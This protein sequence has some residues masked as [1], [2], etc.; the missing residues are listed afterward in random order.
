MTKV[1]RDEIILVARDLFRDR[2]Y[3]GTSM[4]DLAKAVGLKKASLYSHFASKEELVEEA[5]SLTAAQL[6]ERPASTSDWKADYEAA[7]NHVVNY[8]TNANR[9][10]GMHLLYGAE[11]GFVREKVL[12]FFQRLTS[13]F[14]RI[15]Q[16][17]MPETQAWEFAEDTISALEGAT[18]WLAVRGDDAPLQ[19]SVNELKRRLSL[20]A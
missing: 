17:G 4:G 5:L 13:L 2:G 9:C 8:L 18:V 15:L 16:R 11:E 14:A 12:I 6:V 1:T 3:M 10:V 7:V 20:L 19:R